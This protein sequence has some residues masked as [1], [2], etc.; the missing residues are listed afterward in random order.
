MSN[1]MNTN[2][3]I[4]CKSIDLDNQTHISATFTKSLYIQAYPCGRRGTNHDS[5]T[6]IPF[7]PEARLNTEANNRKHSGLNGFTQ[8]YLDKWDVWNGVLSL[9]LAGYLFKINLL[10]DFRAAGYKND[11]T[12]NDEAAAQAINAFGDALVKVLN[13]TDSGKIYANILIEDVHLFSGFTDYYTGVLRNQTALGD[14]PRSV[15]DLPID[16]GNVTDSSSDYYFSGLSFSTNPVTGKSDETYSTNTGLTK[17]VWVSLC[18]MEKKDGVWQVYEPARLPK[19][20]H[21]NNVDSIVVGDTQVNGDLT[22]AAKTETEKLSVSS[23][24]TI[25]DLTVPYKEA[26]KNT[27]ITREG[28]TTPSL[29]ADLITTKGITSKGIISVTDTDDAIATNVGTDIWTRNNITAEGT[30]KTYKALEVTSENPKEPAT[31]NIDKATINQATIA[32]LNTTSITTPSIDAARIDADSANIDEATIAGVGLSTNSN[33]TSI[34]GTNLNLNATAFEVNTLKVHNNTNNATAD[35]DN[36]VT[37]E[38]QIATLTVTNTTA[39]NIAADKLTQNDK[40][41]PTIGLSAT[42][43]GYYQLQITLDPSKN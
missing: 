29:G 12:S 35:I 31:A 41:V 34:T 19:I 8:T 1:E 15:I 18:L 25:A 16:D 37:R 3:F 9:S 24:A 27:H 40:P 5:N 21:G 43:N 4:D 22:V 2:M 13:N 6:R 7:D 38:A 36:L 20:E 26:D 23:A 33:T 28:I 11:T 14:E 30:I 17:Q 42:A 10:P 32:A 39:T